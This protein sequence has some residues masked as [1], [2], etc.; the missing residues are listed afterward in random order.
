MAHLQTVIDQTSASDEGKAVIEAAKKEL[1]QLKRSAKAR[2]EFDQ[3]A[4]RAREGE[5][6][7]KD[8]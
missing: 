6:K 7:P 5:S 3:S 4:A 2:R 1:S 8:G